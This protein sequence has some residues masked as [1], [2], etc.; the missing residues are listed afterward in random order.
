MDTKVL[1]WL[2]VINMEVISSSS[3]YQPHNFL[4]IGNMDS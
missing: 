2:Q 3:K 1:D 4:N